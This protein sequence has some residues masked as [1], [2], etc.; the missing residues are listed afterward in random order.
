MLL[1]ELSSK[2]SIRASSL[3]VCRSIVAIASFFK[4]LLTAPPVSISDETASD[5]RNTYILLPATGALA[6][7]FNYS[8]KL[9]MPSFWAHRKSKYDPPFFLERFLRSPLAALF[10][11]LH[12]F[13]LAL[14]GASFIPPKNKPPIRVVCISDT[15]SHTPSVPPGDLLIHA[16]DLTDDGTQKSIQA[17]L[18]WLNT[19]PHKYK[20]VIAGNHD[21]YLDP[22][23]RKDEDKGT[24][25]RLKWGNII[26]LHNRST[27]LKFK[28]GRIL[29][30][31]GSPDIP[32]CGGKSFACVPPSL[33]RSSCTKAIKQTITNPSS[34]FQYAPD[35]PPW[36]TRIPISTDVL[37]THTPP[38]HHLDI[39]LGCPGLLD[40]IWHVK[41]RLHVFGHVHSGYGR[42]AVF[43]DSAQAAYERLTARSG[44][45]L[46]DLMP[47]RGWVDAAE[48]VW[49]GVKGILWQW[50]MV[51]PK[52]GGGGL[53]VN[54]AMTFQSTSE[55]GN[56]AQVVEL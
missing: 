24:R 5:A 42:E 47:G 41:P 11:Y 44:G 28:G 10:E 14:R 22:L 2:A 36:H 8:S 43:W 20:I 34:S 7:G 35:S 25:T 39:D 1:Y 33:S 38:K 51:G 9:R 26:Y 4:L 31:Y 17:A 29:N 3:R 45:V 50:L 13:L 53:L 48:V 55:I 54:A 12:F 49:H 21:S 27:H 30:I 19:L 37:I 18:D 16:G 6:L 46:A 23:A 32:K 40:R 15:H 56:V 52:G